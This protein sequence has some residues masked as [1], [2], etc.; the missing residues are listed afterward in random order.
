MKFLYA[1]LLTFAIILSFNIGFNIAEKNHH[2]QLE[3]ENSMC[4]AP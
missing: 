2:K 1:V 3:R 4:I